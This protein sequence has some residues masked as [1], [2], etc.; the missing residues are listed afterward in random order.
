MASSSSEK[1]IFLA[2]LEKPSA[3]ERNA[4]LE[5]AYA[6]NPAARLEIERLLAA[7]DRLPSLASPPDALAPAVTVDDP[8]VE[9]PG[10]NIGFYKLLEEIGEGGFGVVFLAEQT[11]PV[12]R[13]VALKVLKPGMDTRQVVARFEAE[14][15]A[16]AIMDHP[17]IAKV[18]DGGA[19]AAGRPYFVMELVQGVPITRYC[20][21]HH[22]TP[23]QRLDL[24]LRACEAV[25]HAHQK[26]VIHRDLKPSNVLVGDSDDKQVL[27][28]IDFGVAKAI[29]LQLTEQTIHT[30]SGQMIGTPLYMSPEQAGGNG[31]D[32]D[33][34]SDIYSL[35]AVVYEL[36]TGTTVVSRDRLRDAS[37]DEI[38]RIVREEEPPKPSDRIR[39]LG[40]EANAVSAQRKSDPRRLSQLCRGELDWIVMKALEK[41]RNRRYETAS[42]LA[43]DVQHYLHDEPVLAGPPSATY[44]FRKFVRRNKEWV[45]AGSLIALMLL[46][47][48]VGLGLGLAAVE[49]ER[50]KVSL[51]RDEKAHALEAETQARIDEQRAREQAM[52]ALRA[53]TEDL[54]ENQLARATHLTDEN[55]EF[56]RNIIKHYEGFAAVTA[57]NAAGRAIRA[58]G[59]FRVGLLR[60]RLGELDEAKRAQADALDIRKQLVAEFPSRPEF[61]QDLAISHNNLG[62]LLHVTGNLPEAETA[63]SKALVIQKRLVADFPSRPEFREDLAKSYNNLGIFLHHTGKVSE[64]VTAYSDA[65][66]IHNQLVADFPNRPEFR[67]RLGAGHLNLATLL[68]DIGKRQEATTAFADALSIHK[69]LVADFPTRP[70]FRRNLAMCHANM[71]L[72]LMITSKP[73]EADAAYCDAIAI[74]KQ[75]AAE[76]PTRPEFRQDLAGSYNSLGILFHRKGRLPEATAAWSEAIAIHK[77]LTV[78]YPTR[79]D[80]REQMAETSGN[81]AMVL[82]DSGK[83]DEAAQAFAENLA[84]RKKLAADFPTL[85]DL[86]NGVAGTLVNLAMLCNRRREFAAAAAHLEEASPYHEAALNANPRHPGYRQFYRNNLWVLAQARAGLLDQTGAVH[87]AEKIRDLGWDAGGNAYEAGCALARCIPIVK[88]DTTLDVAM[89]GAAMQFYGDHAMA[90]LRDALAKGFKDAARMKKNPDLRPLYEREDYKTFVAEMETKQK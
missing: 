12:R 78:D 11:Q 27:K 85:P 67:Q 88:S 41:D 57:D 9:R 73:R 22:L 86:R 48:V 35:G 77:Q 68:D 53:M 50:N 58:E 31:L 75:L 49:Q 81:L 37:Y 3:E 2:A 74:Q 87:A 29:G 47:G 55:K 76:F 18:H 14:R 65:L 56:L 17:N 71:G 84:M 64:A 15:Q 72:F 7:H 13:K 40:S 42:A 30:G 44:R 89:R 70:E 5:M 8:C 21:E 26:G 46:V 60:Y 32:I 59:R 43:A 25:Q 51:E 61:R 24:F 39:T 82:R 83:L 28:V 45:L 54:V 36:L 79:L 66:V 62:T 23:K 63:F 10:T 34:R 52:A 16:L 4:Y 19:T 20:D 6:G 38:R 69:Q 1:S 80:F 90:M 33:T